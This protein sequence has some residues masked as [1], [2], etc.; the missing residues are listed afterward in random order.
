M[1]ALLF[2]HGYADSV[3]AIDYARLHDMGIR[4]LIFDIDNTLVPHGGDATA[5]VEALFRRLHAQGFRTLLL[6]NNSE[7][8]IRH[9][10]RHIGTRYIHNARKPSPAAYIKAVETLGLDKSEV[11]V[12][13]DQLFTDV[14]G[15]GR[16]GLKSILVRYIG[17]ERKEWKG[18]RRMA[19]RIVL[20]V[21]ALL[22]PSRHRLSSAL[23]PR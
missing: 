3:L 10:N 13:G 9:F 17:H 5:E 19:E 12:I 1:P 2:P 15:A 8:R 4:G 20:A 7:A 18:W 16:S 14:L 21:Y 6:S 23:Q 11:V 22:P